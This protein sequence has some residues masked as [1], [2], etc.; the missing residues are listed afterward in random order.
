MEQEGG[1]VYPQAQS[2]RSIWLEAG[3]AVTVRI[4]LFA[5]CWRDHW[6][7][8]N[9][10][11]ASGPSKESQIKELFM[12]DT[13]PPSLEIR[14]GFV[15]SETSAYKSIQV[16]RISVM[17]TARSVAPAWYLAP[18]FPQ[19][20]EIELTGL[21]SHLQRLQR[22]YNGAAEPAEQPHGLV[23]RQCIGTRKGGAFKSF[24][25]APTRK[26]LEGGM[27]NE[28]Q[29]LKLS[30]TLRGRADTQQIRKLARNQTESRSI[31]MS[32]QKKD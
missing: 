16:P 28:E 23:A 18:S 15:K 13:H 14:R 10:L 32:S 3:D 9:S 21:T 25:T 1:L 6:I 26:Q 4:L 24:I 7:E 12:T 30:A 8:C 27:N 2:P 22:T 29:S 20:R 17:R 31:R 11:G 5:L 19:S